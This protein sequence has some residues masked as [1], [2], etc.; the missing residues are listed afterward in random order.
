M[1][2]TYYDIGRKLNIKVALI[3]DTHDKSADGVI[4]SVKENAPD[5]VCMTGDIVHKGDL[6][7]AKNVDKLIKA[8]VS[9]AP[10]LLSLGNHDRGLTDKDFGYLADNGVKVLTND[11]VYLKGA[12]FGGFPSL[13]GKSG[14]DVKKSL[15]FIKD[16]KK[17]DGFKILLCH[18]P[19]YY[20]KFALDDYVDLVL[21][22]HA[23][24]GQ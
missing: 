3:A 22:G 16:F 2:T 12:Y 5:V 19:E 11:C 10:T 17:K 18:H 13:R 9:V 20:D 23:H 4:A 15:A 24:G 21:S 1:K 7:A 14:D 8:C 6:S